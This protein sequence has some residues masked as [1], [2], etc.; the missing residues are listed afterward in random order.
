MILERLSHERPFTIVGVMPPDLDYPTGIEIWRTT[1]S[2]PT[3][4]PFGDAA[5]REVNLVGRLRT[6]VTV[7]HLYLSLP[8]VRD[9]VVVPVPREARF[10]WPEELKQGVR[11]R[12]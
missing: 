4:G 1:K 2:V 11:A 5:R 7:E 8:G 12:S 6:G 9:D 3:D 10:A